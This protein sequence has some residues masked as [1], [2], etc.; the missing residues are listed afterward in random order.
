MNSKQST[1][2]LGNTMNPLTNTE[3]DLERVR[4]WSDS[5]TMNG[6]ITWCMANA[7]LHVSWVI[8]LFIFQLYQVRLFDFFWPKD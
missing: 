2:S 7:L 8:C 5:I 4:R 6:W 1:E 3:K